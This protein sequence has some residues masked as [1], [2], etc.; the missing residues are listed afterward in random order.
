MEL[1]R[2]NDYTK[3][4]LLDCF[5]HQIYY[6]RVGLDWSRQA[7]TSILK[8]INFFGKLV[9]D[10]GATMCFISEKEQKSINF[11]FDSLII[12]Q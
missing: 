3:G 1:P 9:E 7:N 11:C 2:Y 5:Y 6:K 10:D 8:Q 4:N 12:T